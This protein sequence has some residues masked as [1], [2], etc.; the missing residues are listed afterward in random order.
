[1]RL[2][3][4][5]AYWYYREKIIQVDDGEGR[6]HINDIVENPDVFG[7]RSDEISA[8]YDYYKETPGFEGKAREKIMAYVIHAG[9]IRIRE[10]TDRGTIWTI[11]CSSLRTEENDLKELVSF[12]M[13]SLKVLYDCDQV[14][15]SGI[16]DQ[17]SAYFNITGKAIST[18]IGLKK[19]NAV[20]LI[21][22]YKDFL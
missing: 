4:G 15:L 9:W 13:Y 19:I 14:C 12:L 6:K 2:Q 20:R 7:I 21:H 10:R 22:S 8:I 11:Q 5:K 1:V 17:T 3:D 18:F 16:D